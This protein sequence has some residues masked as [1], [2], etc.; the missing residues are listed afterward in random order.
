M[1]VTSLLGGKVVM[2]QVGCNY[3]VLCVL[4]HVALLADK[5]DTSR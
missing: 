5:V 3:L 1:N 4:L 2:N